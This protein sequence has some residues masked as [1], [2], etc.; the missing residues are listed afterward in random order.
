M[1]RLIV[2][3]LAMSGCAGRQT[4]VVMPPLPAEAR[5]SSWC[6]MC[7]QEDATRRIEDQTGAKVVWPIEDTR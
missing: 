2:L 5:S 3:A 1:I 4:Y 6:M 7:W